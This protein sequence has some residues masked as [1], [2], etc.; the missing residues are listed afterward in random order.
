M[1]AQPT[2]SAPQSVKS[3]VTLNANAGVDTAISRRSLLGSLALGTLMPG[4]THGFARTDEESPATGD[5]PITALCFSSNHRIWVAIDNWLTLLSWPDLQPLKTLRLDTDKIYGLRLSAK[6]D[7]GQLIAVGGVPGEHGNVFGISTTR[8][9]VTW[10]Q[11]VGDDVLRCVD[12]DSKS[13]HLAVG[14]HDQ[15][16]YWS[17]RPEESEGPAWNKLTEHTS[18]VTGLLFL[19]TQKLVSASL[20]QTLRTWDLAENRLERRMRQHAGG[21]ESLIRLPDS[22]NSLA[23]CLSIAR[24]KT[25]RIWQP[26]IG[27]QVRIARLP[28]A[29]RC[30][31]TALD[32]NRIWIGGS[33]GIAYAFDIRSVEML[34]KRKLS[35]APLFSLVREPDGG[36]WLAG[37]GRGLTEPQLPYSNS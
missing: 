32:S 16:I 10:Q 1:P 31:C 20:D 15:K 17:S 35:D 2:R 4:I 26:T 8:H 36:R 6:T 24:D 27:R 18:A 14:S 34:E 13:G 33:D 28:I 29:G 30:G 37:T 22:R 23:Q 11:E 5:S 9:Q 3:D 12:E 7:A 25:A 21:I 19:G